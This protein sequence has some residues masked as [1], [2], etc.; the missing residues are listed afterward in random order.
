[1][2]TQPNPGGEIESVQC[3]ATPK[4]EFHSLISSHIEGLDIFAGGNESRGG[5]IS[6]SSNP[7]LFP[8][9]SPSFSRSRSCSP[10]LSK[11]VISVFS[12]ASTEDVLNLD[13]RYTL[14]ARRQTF[15]SPSGG[16]TIKVILANTKNPKLAWGKGRPLCTVKTRVLTID[17]NDTDGKTYVSTA[18]LLYGIGYG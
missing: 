5:E 4:T 7:L 17:R 18:F 3:N 9:P 11:L 16:D 1:M 10:T 6:V 14:I 2:A 15:L 8:L 12:M 13:E